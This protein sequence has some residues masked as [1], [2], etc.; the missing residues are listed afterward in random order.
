MLFPAL[1]RYRHTNTT[2]K[3]AKEHRKSGQTL[4]PPENRNPVKSTDASS[5]AATKSTLRQTNPRAHKPY[6]TQK[7]LES[8]KSEHKRGVRYTDCFPPLPLHDYTQDNALPVPVAASE[9]PYG[10]R[11]RDIPPYE[12]AASRQEDKT[13]NATSDGRYEQASSLGQGTG[14]SLRIR[15]IKEKQ[16]FADFILKSANAC[17]PA[18]LESLPKTVRIF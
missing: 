14:K 17:I 13:C 10:N 1:E 15:I 2:V 7:P 8:A 12:R 11:N 9:Y 6:C 3:T 18:G 5:E 16:A 4:P